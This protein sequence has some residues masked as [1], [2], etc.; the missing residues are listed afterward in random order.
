M[1]A[2]GV[3][4]SLDMVKLR[5]PEGISH[6]STLS[7][8]L[9]AISWPDRIIEVSEEDARPLLGAGFQRL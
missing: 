9:L 2:R 5:A 8:R 7:G 6:V 1:E 4:R 3:G